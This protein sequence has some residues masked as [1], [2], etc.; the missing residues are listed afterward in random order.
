MSETRPLAAAGAILVA[1]L[2][3]GFIDN[4]VVVIAEGAGLWQF[5]ATR[6]V[7]ALPMI[8]G[9]A[10]L[11]LGMGAL[12]VQR[13]W[14]VAARSFFLSTAMMLYFGSLAFLPVAEVAA[15]LFTSPLFVLA[16]SALFLG[17]HVGPVRI[18]AGIAGFAGVLMVLRPDAGAF[19][20]VAVVPVLAGLFYAV[21]ALATR[22]WCAG[23]TGSAL[24][25]GSFVGMGLWGVAGVIFLTV[26]PQSPADGAD[27][28]IL[29]GWVTPGPEFWLWTFVQAIGS[30]IAV[31]FLV[32][33]YQLA[34]ASFVSVFE[35]SLLIFASLWAFVL[36]GDLLDGWA[37]A[38]IG[39]IILSGIA[40]AL[41]GR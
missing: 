19:S 34:E 15:G 17:H 3:I 8:A 5:H 20:P 23:E 39:L 14:A 24:L 27:G 41:R 10:A 18:I 4:F 12:K 6:T 29:R 25:A 40:I 28:F 9:V 22:T 7:I 33:G 16:I 35:Y 36:R 31:A 2:V 21:S 30:V 13:L 38:G 37:M 1:M 32:R 11:G 26:F